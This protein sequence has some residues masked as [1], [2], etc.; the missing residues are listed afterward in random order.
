MCGKIC[1]GKTTFAEQLHKDINGVILSCDEIML[2]LFDEN[3]GERHQIVERNCK[4]YLYT[5]AIRIA[6][7][8]TNVILDCG[9]WT[10]LER[11][12]TKR[13]FNSKGINT[14][15]HYISVDESTQKERILLRNAQKN[16]N[17]YTITK[18]IL[19]KCNSMFEPPKDYELL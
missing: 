15:L 17:T 7:C 1:S 16:C 9:F 4:D 11:S 18:D 8:N 12:T 19:T 14:K 10:E 6:M 3:L 2:S 13:L 5:I